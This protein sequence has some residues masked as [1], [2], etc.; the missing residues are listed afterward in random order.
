MF[1]C[2]CVCVLPWELDS[3]C[4]GVACYQQAGGFDVMTS[5]SLA[6]WS[7]KQWKL[8]Y[9]YSGFISLELSW[10]PIFKQKLK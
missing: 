8:Q 2:V 6:R 3:W 4:V 5:V 7:K 10:S 9:S 1:T